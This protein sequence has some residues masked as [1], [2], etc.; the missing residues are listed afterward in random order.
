MLNTEEVLRQLHSLGGETASQLVAY[1][2]LAAS[3][4]A[5]GL[6]VLLVILLRHAYYWGHKVDWKSPR[7]TDSAD[8]AAA[9]KTAFYALCAVGVA[10]LI[11]RAL[12]N[13]A[14]WLLAPNAALL[15]YVIDL[16]R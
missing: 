14:M 7:V 5:L 2:V 12:H 4:E 1:K 8:G 11:L 13:G 15:E 16:L 6:G 3:F 10:V 9:G